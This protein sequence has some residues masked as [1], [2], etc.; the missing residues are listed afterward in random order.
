MYLD[1][2]NCP[3][4][5]GKGKGQRY[6][7]SGHLYKNNSNNLLKNKIRKVGVNNIKIHFLHRDINEEEAFSWERYWI[8]YIGRRDLGLGTLCNLTDGGDGT[9]GIIFTAE[10]RQKIGEIHKDKEISKEHRQKISKFHRG[11]KRS[12][13]TKRKMR[14]ALK[15][16]PVWNK[17]KNLLE[18]HRQKISEANKGKTSWNKG[19][20][21]GPPSEEHKKKISK[22][23]QGKKHTE[24]TK[25]KMSKARLGKVPWNKGKPMTK[26]QKQKISETK[27]RKAS[28]F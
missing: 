13:E 18:E 6:E 5:I 1:L 23:L 4:Y 14:A 12:E 10:H 27:R 25:Q 8:K 28:R 3:F 24:E 20:T 21:L 26:E 15:N 17:G 16:R 2:D 19:K 9:N 22:A 7:V 11:R